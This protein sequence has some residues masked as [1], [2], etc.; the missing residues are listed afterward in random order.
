MVRIHFDVSRILETWKYC[1]LGRDLLFAI[2]ELWPR[3]I[4]NFYPSTESILSVAEGLRA[5]FYLGLLPSSTRF[6]PGC[7][8]PLTFRFR[9]LNSF[10]FSAFFLTFTPN[11]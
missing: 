2:L 10:L 6:S 4:L 7:S 3:T 9:Y 11:L 8:L 1:R 5:C